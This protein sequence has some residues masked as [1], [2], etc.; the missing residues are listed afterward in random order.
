M[1]QFFLHVCAAGAGTARRVTLC[2]CFVMGP[3]E[4]GI[5]PIFT[6][7]REGALTMQAGGG[8]GYDFS[9]LRPALRRALGRRPHSHAE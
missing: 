6:A 9:P 4:D 8:V 1:A 3:V 5:D 7:L 2:N